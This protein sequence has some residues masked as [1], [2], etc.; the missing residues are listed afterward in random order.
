MSGENKVSLPAVMVFNGCNHCHRNFTYAPATDID[1]L[2]NMGYVQCP[3][4]HHHN[5]IGIMTNPEGTEA[6]VD[7]SSDIGDMPCSI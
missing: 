1:V 6:P 2:E 3:H 7:H 5:C 4:C